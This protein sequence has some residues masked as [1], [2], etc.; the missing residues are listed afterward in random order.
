LVPM[1]AIGL[2]S[3]F[4]LASSPVVRTVGVIVAL[5]L[6][7]L[8]ASR[9]SEAQVVRILVALIVVLVVVNAAFRGLYPLLLDPHNLYR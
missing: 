7:F 6:A 2:S 8:A 3:G 1:V 9:F 5:L 4:L